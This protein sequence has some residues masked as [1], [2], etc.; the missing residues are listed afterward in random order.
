MGEINER[1]SVSVDCPMSPLSASDEV[2][3]LSNDVFNK[4][5]GFVNGQVQGTTSDYKLI[6]EM[7]MSTAQRYTDMKQVA[8]TISGR[9]YELGEKYESLR[10]YLQ[11]VDEIE[12]ASKRLE[13]VVDTLENYV[14]SLEDKLRAL[15]QPISQRM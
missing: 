13:S 7:N 1:A 3:Q 15:Q 4:V 11:Q 5:S 12:A 14:T 6:E 2:R 10:P 8:S 9:L